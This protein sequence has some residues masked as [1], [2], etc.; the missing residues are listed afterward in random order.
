MTRMTIFL[1]VSDS[2][3]VS[4]ANPFSTQLLANADLQRE[5]IHILTTRIKE[6]QISDMARGSC[7]K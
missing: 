7:L 2:E 1:F 3:I 6:E 4:R 5:I